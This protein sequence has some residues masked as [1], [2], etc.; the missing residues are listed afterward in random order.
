M[1]QARASTS[2]L[3]IDAVGSSSRSRRSPRTIAT[4][5][6]NNRT[7]VDVSPGRCRQHGC[8]PAVAVASTSCDHR[9]RGIAAGRHRPSRM[10]RRRD[11][12]RDRRRS[13]RVADTRPTPGIARSTTLGHDTIEETR[14]Q[15]LRHAQSVWEG[16]ATSRHPPH[17]IFA[18][19][20]IIWLLVR[21]SERA[22]DAHDRADS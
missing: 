10:A 9:R 15:Y 4:D 6:S 11:V 13:S 1:E 21:T 19:I 3:S 22:S 14:R 5:R 2:H 7:H 16:C 17:K 20:E 12:C 18:A 8:V